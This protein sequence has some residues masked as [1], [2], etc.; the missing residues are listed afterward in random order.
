[1]DLRQMQALCRC[2]KGTL[3]FKIHPLAAVSHLRLACCMLMMY[4]EMAF[5][6][7]QAKHPF[8]ALCQHRGLRDQ[9]VHIAGFE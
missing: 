1:M 8:P 7:S 6:R 4:C 9:D 2:Q 3:R 5:C